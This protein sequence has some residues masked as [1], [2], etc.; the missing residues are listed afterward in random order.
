[1]SVLVTGATGFI[2]KALIAAL[3]DRGVNVR[4]TRRGSFCKQRVG[5]VSWYPLDLGHDENWD[6]LLEGVSV[7]YHL[8]WTT[9]PALAAAN[10]TADFET[11]LPATQRL[12]EAAR[13]KKGIRIVFPSSGGTIYGVTRDSP[14][15]ETHPTQPISVYGAAKLA[16][17]HLLKVYSVQYGVNSVALRIANPYGGSQSLNKGLGA[18]YAFATAALMEQPIILYGDGSTVRDFIHI[19]DVT[20]ALISAGERWDVE[21]AV[22]IGSGQ[23]V[24]LSEI[25]AI[26]EAVLGRRI[27]VERRPRRPFDVPSSVLDCSKAAKVLSWRAEIGLYD[28]IQRLVSHLQSELG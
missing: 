13:H 28:G 3:S 21:G 8:A 22:N 19:S 12:L 2:G 26:L 14:I 24:A 7:I 5:G 23:G 15:T 16:T 17:E 25:I 6:A 4:A 1:M 20:R 18:I 10:P 11:N 9:T 27:A